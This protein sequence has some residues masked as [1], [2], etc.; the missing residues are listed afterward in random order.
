MTEPTMP[1]SGL[2]AVA[3]TPMLPGGEVDRESLATLMDFYVACGSTGVALLGVMGEANRMTD[4][5]AKDLI[6]LAL[7][8]LG[9]RVPVIV[10]VSDDSLARVSELSRFAA[11]AGAAGVLL[12]PL[13]GSAGDRVVAGYFEQAEDAIGAG[14]PICVQDFPKASGVQI[15]LDAWRMIVDSCSSVQMLKAESEPGLEKLSAIR[16]AEKSGLRRVT[17]LTGNNGIHLVQELDRG[18]D[19]AMTGFAFPDVLARVMQVFSQ[20]DADGAADLFDDYL[21]VNRHELRMGIS[22]RKEI[23]RRRGAMKHSSARYPAPELSDRT[24]DELT[25]LLDRLERRTGSPISAIVDV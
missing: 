19:G 6:V 24:R 20:G 23:L 7:E 5:A 9:G 14:I 22:V 25:S 11:D 21:P 1:R 17:I 13:R 3:V 8:A 12:Q 16:S 18:A 2:V 4:R 15:S 10:G